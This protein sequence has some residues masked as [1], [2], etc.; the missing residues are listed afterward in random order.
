[1]V[2]EFFY[3]PGALCYLIAMIIS[4]FAGNLLPARLCEAYSTFL[5]VTEFNTQAQPLKQVLSSQPHH[6]HFTGKK[7]RFEGVLSLLSTYLGLQLCVY[8]P[9]RPFFSLPFWTG[10]WGEAVSPSTQCRERSIDGSY[11][12][13]E[14]MQPCRMPQLP[15][16]R[17]SLTDRQSSVSQPS[18][19]ETPLSPCIQTAG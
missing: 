4:P 14:G 6:H 1:M 11:L 12:L 10:T 17:A 9:I 16:G 3:V 2:S 7:Q 13:N 5:P 8:S 18:A 19:R 15:R